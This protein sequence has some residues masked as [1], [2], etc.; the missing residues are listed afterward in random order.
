MKSLFFRFIPFGGGPRTCIGREYARLIIKIAL[1]EM[2]RHYRKW[3]L[4]NK[5]LPKMKAIPTL[6]PADGLPCILY[7]REDYGVVKR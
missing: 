6:H 5:K 4:A 7:P 2:F 1:I 3:E